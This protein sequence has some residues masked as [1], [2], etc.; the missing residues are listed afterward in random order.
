M[1][2]AIII[3]FLIAMGGVLGSC[4]AI[5]LILVIF[6]KMFAKKGVNAQPPQEEVYYEAP[7]SIDDA[8]MFFIN[9]N[10]MK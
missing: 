9:R 5:F 8:I 4:L 7:S 2:K 10:R 6:K 1:S 3:K